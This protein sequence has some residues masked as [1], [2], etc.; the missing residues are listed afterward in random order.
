MLRL[1]KDGCDETLEEAKESTQPTC[2][3]AARSAAAISQSP[4]LPSWG[5]AGTQGAD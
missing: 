2:D 5:M 4:V 3:P 1:Q